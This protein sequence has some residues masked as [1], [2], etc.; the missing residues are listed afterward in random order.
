VLQLESPS[1]NL[2]TQAF[3]LNCCRL[4]ICFSDSF[5]VY[6]AQGGKEG[7]AFGVSRADACDAVVVGSTG[8]ANFD[9]LQILKRSA[10]QRTI[11][12]T[13]QS[14][15]RKLVGHTHIFVVNENAPP[16]IIAPD[17]IDNRLYC[18]F[19]IHKLLL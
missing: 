2:K 8:S 7:A 13:L 5:A 15:P 12:R 10:R 18:C 4:I 9:G 14:V 16:I 6:S 19:L 11:E 17:Q 1:F 3:I